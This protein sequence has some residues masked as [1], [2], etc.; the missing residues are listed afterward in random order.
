MGGRFIASLAHFRWFLS[1]LRNF[2]NK[3]HEVW[4]TSQRLDG[5]FLTYLIFPL[6]LIPLM[7]YKF[8][9]SERKGFTRAVI[10]INY[11]IRLE[12]SHCFSNNPTT[13]LMKF[14]VFTKTAASLSPDS[15]N[16]ISLPSTIYNLPDK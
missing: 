9:C 4:A 6:H 10:V 16:N 3:P 1:M 12:L 15:I 2:L 5:K 11:L 13:D 8:R 7:V 14:G